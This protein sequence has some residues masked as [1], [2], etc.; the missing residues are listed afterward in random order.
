MGATAS[1]VIALSLERATRPPEDKFPW[2]GSIALRIFRGGNDETMPEQ[3]LTVVTGV[4]AAH[5][6]LQRHLVLAPVFPKEKGV[7]ARLNSRTTRT[8]SLTSVS[9]WA[10]EH[11]TS[12]FSFWSRTAA[13]ALIGAYTHASAF[14][15]GRVEDFLRQ[16]IPKPP[17]V[18]QARIEES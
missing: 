3:S 16:A 7:H 5:L 8:T 2:R 12:S 1:L 11:S 9:M 13:Y 6:L 4:V 15:R 17:L 18:M 10:S 14:V